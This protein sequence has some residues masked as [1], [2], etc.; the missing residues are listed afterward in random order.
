MLH[1]SFTYNKS[2]AIRQKPKADRKLPNRSSLDMPVYRPLPWRIDCHCLYIR[3][4]W[5]ACIS[6][7][8]RR[9]RT[10]GRLPDN[11]QRLSVANTKA[12]C[13]FELIQTQTEDASVNDQRHAMTRTFTDGFRTTRCIAFVQRVEQVSRSTAAFVHVTLA[14][15]NSRIESPRRNESQTTRTARLNR[16]QVAFLSFRQLDGFLCQRQNHEKRENSSECHHQSSN[17]V[18]V[19]TPG[20]VAVALMVVESAKCGSVSGACSNRL[21][22]KSHWWYDWKLL[23]LLP[24]PEYTKDVH[25]PVCVSKKKLKIE[26]WQLPTAFGCKHG[27]VGSLSLINFCNPVYDFTISG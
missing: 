21:H 15:A 25:F 13:S 16:R 26:A 14:L 24:Q 12:N 8:W 11:A 4:K 2:L 6:P 7:S 27:A 18:I 22:L 10:S 5:T 20:A 19:N 9:K 17:V 1:D 23:A 3:R